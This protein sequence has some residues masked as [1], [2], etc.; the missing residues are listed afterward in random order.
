MIN[1][2]L[3][4]L[5]RNFR[6]QKSYSL[7]NLSSFVIGLSCAILVFLFVRYEFSYDRYH[8]NSGRIYR[9]LREHQGDAAW[10]N[11]SEHPLAAALQAEFPEVVKA[12]RLKK[13]DE[14]GV[15]EHGDKR[16]YEEAIFFA[17]QDFLGIFSFPLVSG[18]ASTA[19]R[20]PF[21]VLLTRPMAEKYFGAEDPVGKS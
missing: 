13:N 7:I 18:D 14:V 5:I 17:D 19:L 11:S 3:R 9:V 21:S 20:E 16:F 12:T 8:E 15:V 10:S 2:Y 4:V 1:H 6:R